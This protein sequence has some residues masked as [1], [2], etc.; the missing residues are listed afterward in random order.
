M[1][2]A[3]NLFF[4]VQ[5]G[6][7]KENGVP[8]ADYNFPLEIK[9]PCREHYQNSKE[10][11]VEALNKFSYQEKYRKTFP[12]KKPAFHISNRYSH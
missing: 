4:S 7:R 2:L 6:L 3:N 11:N 1:M 10:C 5:G 8:V 12:K 9:L